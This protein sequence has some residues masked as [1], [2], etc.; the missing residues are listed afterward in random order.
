VGTLLKAKGAQIRSRE[1]WIELG[2]KNNSYFLGLEKQRQVNKSINK[3]K[4]D[5]NSVITDQPK[6]LHMIKEYYEKLY[7]TTKPNKELLENYIF[8][9]NLERNINEEEFKICD[10]KLTIEECTSA[11]NMMKLNKSPGLDGLT[12]EFYQTF[13]DKIKFFLVD[14]LNK[15]QDEKLLT[16]SQR[17]SVLSL[18]L[19]NDDPLLLENDR[20]ISLLNV[21]LKL[22]SY[23]LSQRLKKIL[24]KIINEN[25]TC[26]LQIRFIGFNHRQIQDIID[27]ADSYTIDGAMIFVD[28]IKAFDTLE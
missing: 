24:P 10:G 5:K 19:K 16:Y 27:F 3:L 9:T 12:V 22:L 14:V 1:K 17:T 8:E 20:P 15:S 13:W 7:T 28:F 26:Y 11:F 18:I 25:Q 6:L 21:D 2:E 4:D 23:V